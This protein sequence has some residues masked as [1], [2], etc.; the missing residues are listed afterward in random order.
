MAMVAVLDR[1]TANLTLARLQI[2]RLDPM[3]DR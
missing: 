2:E 1:A 3:L